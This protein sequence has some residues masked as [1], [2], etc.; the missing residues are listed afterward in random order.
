MRKADLR[1]VQGDPKLRSRDLSTSARRFVARCGTRH[2]K[3]ATSACAIDFTIARHDKAL[4]G[5]RRPEEH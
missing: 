3:R 2:E 5:T 1:V 4:V